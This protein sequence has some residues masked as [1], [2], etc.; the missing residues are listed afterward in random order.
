MFVAAAAAKVYSEAAA[1]VLLEPARLGQ[2]EL[3]E[4]ALVGL[5][6]IRFARGPAS[7]AE[8]ASAEPA[9]DELASEPGSSSGSTVPSAGFLKRIHVN[10][11]TL[12]VIINIEPSGDKLGKMVVY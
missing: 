6:K 10:D 1:A 2:F 7:A 5:L 12:I 8:Q 3:F 4:F 9:S 11:K